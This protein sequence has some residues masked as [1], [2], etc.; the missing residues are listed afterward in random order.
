MLDFSTKQSNFVS[1][2]LVSV[3]LVSVAS[4]FLNDSC[5]NVGCLL[6]VVLLSTAKGGLF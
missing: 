6:L 3:F 5:R 2:F 4:L 1:V